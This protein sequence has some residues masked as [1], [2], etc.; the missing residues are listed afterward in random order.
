MIT[1]GAQH[2]IGLVL[3]TLLRRADRL[4]VDIPSYPHAIDAFRAAGAR[5]VPIAMP[6]ARSNTGEWERVLLASRPEF[7]YLMPDFH[8]P[9]GS[10]LD[11][12]ERRRLLTAAAASGTR[13][14]VDEATAELAIDRRDPVP[15][16]AALA[17]GSG[18]EVLT[19]GS[20]GKTVWHGLRIGW[21]RADS[22]TIAAIAA[23]RPARDLGT[24]VLEQ[25]VVAELLP[26]FGRVLEDRAEQLRATRAAV[27]DRL[28]TEL[29]DWRVPVPEG[30]LSI[31][32]TLPSARSSLLVSAAAALG[33]RIIAG[34]RFG[35]DGAFVR[36]L[37]IP[38]GGSPGPISDA[39][40]VLAQAWRSTA[41]AVQR[42]ESYGPVL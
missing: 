13:L 5:I 35:L 38:I 4:V 41:A 24:P 2:A 34:P 39:I 12:D 36:Q 8:N 17:S 40:G 23:A 3:H 22:R 1:N 9:T 42:Q 11:E 14:L 28:A 25:L 18:A 10:S 37:R 30:G 31:W 19:I 6:D 32:A 15:P 21:I 27:V 33:L 20:V 26:D 16:L 29:P 7:A